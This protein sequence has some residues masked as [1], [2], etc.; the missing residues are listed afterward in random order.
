M[1]S[2]RPQDI[3]LSYDMSSPT[4]SHHVM[5]G[6]YVCIPMVTVFQYH[7]PLCIGIHWAVQGVEVFVSTVRRKH[8]KHTGQCDVTRAQV[9]L[10][11][12]LFIRIRKTFRAFSQFVY[13]TLYGFAKDMPGGTKS[14]DFICNR[15]FFT[16]PELHACLQCVFMFLKGFKDNYVKRVPVSDWSHEIPTSAVLIIKWSCE[17][18]A[19]SKD[20]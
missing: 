14:F 5:M 9:S 11:I 17:S 7:R 6:Q 10:M 8:A 4:R 16:G 1:S 13:S 18:C 20:S 2:M 15:L 12:S 3:C 19:R